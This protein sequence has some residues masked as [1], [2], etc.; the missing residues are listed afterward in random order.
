MGGTSMVNPLDL[1]GMK[2]GRSVEVTSVEVVPPNLPRDVTV[3][4]EV[5][6]ITGDTLYLS[7]ATALPRGK[8]VAVHEAPTSL[9][10]DVTMATLAG[11]AMHL[12][13]NGLHTGFH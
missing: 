10:H 5:R 1:S 11:L 2:S 3:S 13:I 9:F 8:I 12:A 6:L 4:G 7:D